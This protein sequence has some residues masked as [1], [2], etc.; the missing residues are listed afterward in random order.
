MESLC[1]PGFQWST[2]PFIAQGMH[3]YW[4]VYAPPFARAFQ[5]L[6]LVLERNLS[7]ACLLTVNVNRICHSRIICHIFRNSAS[8]HTG[9]YNRSCKNSKWW[10]RSRTHILAG[11]LCAESL[12]LIISLLE[13]FKLTTSLLLA[14]AQA[15]GFE[16]VKANFKRR[17]CDCKGDPEPILVSHSTSWTN[18]LVLTIGFWI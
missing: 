4:I 5:V 3:F 7:W 8:M 1:N 16:P 6:L 18:L 9:R 15:E 14:V 2:I 10:L 12:V 11:R 13:H 17:W